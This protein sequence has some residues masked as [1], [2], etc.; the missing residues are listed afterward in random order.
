MWRPDA[1]EGNEAAKIRC[2]I[3]PYTRGF[4]LDLG[5]GP[6]KAFPHF[7]GID[8]GADNG[9]RPYPNTLQGEC[10][11]LKKFADNALD[12]VFS[13]HLLEHFADTVGVLREW[14]RVIKPGGHLV[15]YLPHKLLYPNIGEKGSN[16]DHKRDF[17]EEDIIGAMKQMSAGW[18]LIENEIR[19]DYDEYSFFQVFRKRSDRQQKIMPWRKPPKAA[20]VV[21]YGAMGDHIMAQS[22]VPQLKAQGY[23]VT[24]NTNPRGEEVLKHHEGIDAMLIQDQDQ[25]PNEMLGEYWRALSERYDKVINL[26]ESVEGQLLPGASNLRFHYAD[27][28]RHRL[29]NKNYLEHTHDIAAVPYTFDT[30]FRSTP[31]EQEWAQKQKQKMTGGTRRLVH[32]ALVGSAQHK[33]W[34][35]WDIL[36][37]WIMQNTDCQIVTTGSERERELDLAILQGYVVA[38]G[39]D[40]LKAAK[41]SESGIAALQKAAAGFDRDGVSRLFARSGV[42]TVRESLSLAQQADLVIGPETG[43]LNAVGQEPMPKIVF[44]SHS[45]EENLTKYWDNAHPMTPERT[46]CYP[47]HRMHYSIDYCPQSA[48]WMS[49][50]CAAGVEPERVFRTLTEALQLRRPPTF[51]AKRDPMDTLLAQDTGRTLGGRGAVLPTA[52]GAEIE[53]ALGTP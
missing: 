15:L 24:Y 46:P 45:S 53:N 1:P 40:R 17:D 28:V 52:L 37:T 35:Y 10:A 13:S 48:D 6:W 33:V 39:M 42:Y 30:R 5:C 34:P 32:I 43:V 47:C 41:L 7:V 9:G 2:L 12:F 22:I 3:V 25:V 27:E 4:G 23:H 26:S 51:P 16:P 36:C 38:M 29:F 50:K 20:L 11:S 44:L 18:D 8:S 31:A 14:W 19:S 21:R 49:A